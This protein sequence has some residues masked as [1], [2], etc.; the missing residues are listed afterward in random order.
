[1]RRLKVYKNINK[2]VKKYSKVCS[3]DNKK[4]KQIDLNMD[5]KKLSL[6]SII[7]FVYKSAIFVIL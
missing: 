2:K 7:I 6:F 3:D 5:L 1:M 4:R